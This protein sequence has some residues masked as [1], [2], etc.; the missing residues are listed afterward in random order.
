MS[1]TQFAFMGIVL[2]HPV[3]C[4]LYYVFTSNNP[5]I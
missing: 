1:G 3:L 4:K 2:L 5:N